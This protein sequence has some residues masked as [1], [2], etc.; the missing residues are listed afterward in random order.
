MVQNEFLTTSFFFGFNYQRLSFV[1]ENKEVEGLLHGAERV[2]RG[3]TPKVE[4]PR[5]LCPAT[6]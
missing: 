1:V 3:G 4:L 5:F 6:L 2:G